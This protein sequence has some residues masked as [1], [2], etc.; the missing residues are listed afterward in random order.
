MNS[1]NGCIHF[2]LAHEADD[3]PIGQAHDVRASRAVAPLHAV[4]V[5]AVGPGDGDLAILDGNGVLAV[6]GEF[7]IDHQVHG[8]H[9]FTLGGD[10]GE[11]GLL[12]PEEGKA[13]EDAGGT[14]DRKEKDPG[15]CF[16]ANHSCRERL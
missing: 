9:G 8:F 13:E 6:H 14:D 2:L 5:R 3:Q 11:P 16:Q 7:L 4:V 15:F 10:L 12:L 1:S